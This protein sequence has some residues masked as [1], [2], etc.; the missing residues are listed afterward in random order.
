[1]VVY[2]YVGIVGWISIKNN[3]HPYTV[4]HIGSRLENDMLFLNMSSKFC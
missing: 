3:L 2:V 4:C 1:M